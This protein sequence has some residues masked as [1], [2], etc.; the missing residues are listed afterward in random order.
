MRARLSRSWLPLGE[1]LGDQSWPALLTVVAALVRGLVAGQRPTG[2]AACP[3]R[4]CL[5]IGH[6]PAFVL[7]MCAPQF[8]Q[9]VGT[10][11]GSLPFFLCL[12]L[13]LHRIRLG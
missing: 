3:A 8:V 13:R 4:R 7:R 6:L 12:R 2:V 9:V 1:Q 11:L 10:H 5:V